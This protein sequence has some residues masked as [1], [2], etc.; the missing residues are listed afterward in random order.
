[1]NINFAAWAINHR[2]LPF[3]PTREIPI[4][5]PLIVPRGKEIHGNPDKPP[6]QRHMLTFC[7]NLSTNVS[8]APTGIPASG[9]VGK[10]A[11]PS[12]FNK[13]V[14]WA[15]HSAWI[16]RSG[17]KSSTCHCLA[18]IKRSLT[19]GPNTGWYVSIKLPSLSQPRQFVIYETPGR[20]SLSPAGRTVLMQGYQRDLP[21]PHKVS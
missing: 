15:R 19:P 14:K 10:I 6:W 16:S 11:N 20:F 7:R 18:N 3:G 5:A 8:L 2:S 12:S 13:S 1:M 21:Q 9:I 17:D 4:G